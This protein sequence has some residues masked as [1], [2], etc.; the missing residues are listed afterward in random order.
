MQGSGGGGGIATLN[1]NTKVEE[2]KS[3]AALVNLSPGIRGVSFVAGAGSYVPT[4]DLHGAR[5]RYGYL[6]SLF[7]CAWK[8][9]KNMGLGSRL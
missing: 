2:A 6:W 3:V 9:I 4:I 5:A 7:V 1:R 8:I